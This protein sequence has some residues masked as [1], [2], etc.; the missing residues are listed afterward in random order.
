MRKKRVRR[1]QFQP[2]TPEENEKR[3]AAHIERQAKMGVD[4]DLGPPPIAGPLVVGI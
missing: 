4:Y 1:P 2:L 3:H